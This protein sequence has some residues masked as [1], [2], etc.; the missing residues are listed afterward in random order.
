MKVLVVDDDPVT[1][2]LI[3]ADLRHFGYDVTAATNGKE[4]F[5][6]VRTGRFHLVVSDWQMPEMNGLDLCREIRKRTGPVT[7]M[8]FCSLRAAG[9]ITLCAG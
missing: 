1:C 4:A 7:F 5:D 9:S 6:L 2:E 3:V 8:S